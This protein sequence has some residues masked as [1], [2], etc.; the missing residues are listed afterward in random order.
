MNENPTMPQTMPSPQ[1]APVAWPGFLLAFA[2]SCIT[3]GIMWDISWHET[4][5]RD[6]F[7]TPAHMVI[8]LGGALGG[9]IGGWLAIKHTFL[10]G[11]AERDASVR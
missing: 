7:W 6:S 10:A 5:G 1:A 11:P 2:A 8:Y 3:V 9:C 4:V